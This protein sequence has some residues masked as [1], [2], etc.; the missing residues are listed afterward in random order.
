MNESKTTATFKGLDDSLT[1][2]LIGPA[3]FSFSADRSVNV[4]VT[5]EAGS[6]PTQH[7]M[8]LQVNADYGEY[9]KIFIQSIFRKPTV[10]TI[11]TSVPVVT[12][13]S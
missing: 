1:V 11:K 2:E 10:L 7:V 5:D 3:I 8:V 13:P 4:I 12:F 6:G 9:K